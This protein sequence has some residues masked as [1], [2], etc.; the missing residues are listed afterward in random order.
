LTGKILRLYP[1]P[2]QELVA[3]SIYEDLELPPPGRRDYSRPYVIMNMVSSIDGRT[4]IG[5][6]ASRIGSETD[7]RVMRTLRSKADAVMI[8]AGTLR[9]E[10][11]SLGL[12]ELSRAAQPLAVIVTKTGNV[13]LGTNLIIGERQEVLVITAEDAS[14]ADIKTLR[15]HASV[16]RLQATSAG[17]VSLEEAL[18]ELEATRGVELLLVEG[19]PR[20]NYSL[21]SRGLA[22]ELFL[23]LASKLLGSTGSDALTLLEGPKFSLPTSPKA[24]LVSIHLSDNE[25]YLRYRF[26]R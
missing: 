6:K 23:T 20:L 12:D 19:G 14:E 4:A 18:K 7:R 8:G 11:M 1:L 10:K 22:D 13:P 16:L 3:E 24:E 15:E 5:G 2:A 17:G 25:L 9:A 26:E 21:V